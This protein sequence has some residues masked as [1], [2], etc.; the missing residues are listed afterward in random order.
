MDDA[1]MIQLLWSRGEEALSALAQRYGGRLYQTALNILGNPQDAQE[2]VN[3][4]YLAI[5]NSIPPN[6]PD[7]LA[8]FVCRVGRNTALNHL[9]RERAQKRDSRFDLSLEEL[10]GCIPGESFE[11]S[12]DARVLGRAIDSFLDRQ[13]RENRVIFLRRYYFGDSVADIA[14]Q[15]GLRENT[16]SVRLHRL[17]SSLKEALIKEDVYHEA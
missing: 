7:P 5:W 4:T 9:R 12:W 13:T 6:R 11:E 10:S 16:V 2:A 17:R 8:G 14:R 3:D 1:S 15:L